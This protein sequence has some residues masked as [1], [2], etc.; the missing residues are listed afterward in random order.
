M[1]AGSEINERRKKHRNDCEL[2]SSRLCQASGQGQNHQGADDTRDH[3]GKNTSELWTLCVIA[4]D[5]VD[6]NTYEEGVSHPRLY[7]A[8]CSKPFGTADQSV[9]LPRLEGMGQLTENPTIF[10]H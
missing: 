8:A 6:K 9:Q 7:A 4:I 3:P 5:T 10:R 1:N 2:S